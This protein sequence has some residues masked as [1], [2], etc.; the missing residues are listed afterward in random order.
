MLYSASKDPTRSIKYLGNKVYAPI[1]N[2]K[3]FSP[4]DK[5][6]YHRFD[7]IRTDETFI[8]IQNIDNAIFLATVEYFSKVV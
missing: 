2:V 4:T 8:H 5:Y 7:H 3:E 1:N 6:L